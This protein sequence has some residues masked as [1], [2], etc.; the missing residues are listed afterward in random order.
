MF[1]FFQDK[2]RGIPKKEI[3]YKDRQYSEQE[4]MLQF[5]EHFGDIG[6]YE[7]DPKEEKRMYDEL[8]SIDYLQP[9]LRGII[10]RDMQLY[11]SATTDQQRDIIKGRIARTASMRSKLVAQPDNQVTNTKMKGLRYAKA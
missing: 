3:V 1:K 4:L 11:F 10:A 6:D 9:Y 7:I 5:A 2:N 8:Q